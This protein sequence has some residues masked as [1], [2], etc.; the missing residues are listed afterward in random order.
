HG[1]SNRRQERGR[2]ITNIMAIPGRCLAHLGPENCWQ[3]ATDFLYVLN[4][5]PPLGPG[6][7]GPVCDF[8]KEAPL[9]LERLQARGEIL[10]GAYPVGFGILFRPWNW[11]WPRG[12]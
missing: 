11:G 4:R 10:Q 5:G 12:G 3:F 9:H 1:I 2:R 8:T 6:V 7:R